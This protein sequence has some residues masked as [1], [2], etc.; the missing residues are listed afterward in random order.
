MLMSV[1]VLA[2]LVAQS[3][4]LPS[5]IVAESNEIVHSAESAIDRSAETMQGYRKSSA[6]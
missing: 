2:M 3:C 5:W 1:T 6:P 4:R